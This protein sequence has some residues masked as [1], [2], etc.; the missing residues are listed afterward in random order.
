VNATG[1][2]TVSA[3]CAA[4]AASSTPTLLVNTVLTN[5]T[6]GTTSAT[7]IG[8]ASGLP[9]GVSAAW[10]A[11]VITISGTPTASGTFSYTIPLTG[12]SCSSVNATGMI[13]VTAACGSVTSVTIEGYS[14]PTVSI[15][16]QC[17]TKE[18]LRV[19]MYND[20][21]AIPLNNTYTSGTVSTVWQGLTTGA[22]TIY[23]NESSTGANATNYGFLYNWYAAKG[24]STSGSTTYKNI[25]PMGWHV[26][27]DA[28]WRTLETYLN[29]VAPTGSVGGKMKSIGTTY[30]NSPNTGANNS[31]GFSALP[32]GFRGFGGSFNFISF[33]AV[34]WSATENDNFYA[35]S[36]NLFSNA[37]NVDRN[38]NNN[39]SV[40]AS[41]RCL[42]G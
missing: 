2:I 14:Y 38:S 26:P 19:T 29:T 34:F 27:T 25:C 3:A 16:T 36:R 7:G 12:T 23:G 35:W 24:V 5:I 30:W 15:G 22:Y 31:S 21:T 18:N 6:H 42:R 1:T 41:V 10:S 37:G 11:D 33:N 13:T 32:G 20:G 40:G 17:W 4:A 39:K 28:E 8:T 9:A